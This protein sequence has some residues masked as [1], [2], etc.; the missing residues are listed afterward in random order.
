MKCI[1]AAENNTHNIT[2]NPKGNGKSIYYLY[3][4][5]RR[6]EWLSFEVHQH[7]QSPLG[8]VACRNTSK[9]QTKW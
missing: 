2:W 8:A 3:E 6:V 9:F 4:N 5:I 7:H 1:V